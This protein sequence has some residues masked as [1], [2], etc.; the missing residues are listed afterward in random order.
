M[1]RSPIESASKYLE[2]N[3]YKILEENDYLFSDSIPKESPNN[4][5][6]NIIKI[7]WRNEGKARTLS[8]S[9][10]IRNNHNFDFEISRGFQI[11]YE[12]VL[13]DNNQT[14]SK[15]SQKLILHCLINKAC[16]NFK[17][18]INSKEYQIIEDYNNQLF[19]I[20]EKHK[21]VCL[22]DDA[23]I[24]R[25]QNVTSFYSSCTS[26]VKLQNTGTTRFNNEK[27]LINCSKDI[28]YHLGQLIA[29]KALLPIRIFKPVEYGSNSYT[30]FQDR[31]TLRFVQQANT[32]FEKLYNYW[33]A[34]GDT[35]HYHLKTNLKPRQVGF[36]KVLEALNQKYPD[37]IL[38]S[39]EFKWLYDFKNTEFKDINGERKDIVHYFNLETKVWG[40]W[41]RNVSNPDELY[42]IEKK[43]F[44]LVD[45]FENEL[46]NCIV[47]FEMALAFIQK[48]SE[49][50]N[51]DDT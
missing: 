37:L 31:P 11:D 26:G 19:S 28:K 33:D 46:K 12:T 18:R 42:E 9:E 38:V 17:P 29:Y 14:R 2:E 13:H 22:S 43:L 23:C 3:D 48:N 1:K 20:Y 47:G 39:I 4:F 16:T 45:K 36:I 6:L 35:L 7:T 25:D 44:G 24:I 27:E 32:L 8:Q 41:I 30:F 50:I 5:N 21:L 49:L 34:I 15:Y 40:D 10:I 51:N